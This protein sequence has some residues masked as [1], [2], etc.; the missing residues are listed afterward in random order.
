MRLYYYQYEIF[1]NNVKLT[2]LKVIGFMFY[3]NLACI[4]ILSY[5]ITNPIVCFIYLFVCLFCKR[6][7]ITHS[8]KIVKELCSMLERTLFIICIIESKLVDE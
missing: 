2:T 7:Y 1:Y 5:N 3:E 4:A 6:I 8:N